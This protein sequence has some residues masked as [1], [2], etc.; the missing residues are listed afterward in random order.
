MSKQFIH[1]SMAVF[2][3]AGSLFAESKS[4]SM[5]LKK[6]TPSPN[7][8]EQ[9]FSIEKDQLPP[10]YGAPSRINVSNGRDWFVNASFIYWYVS[11]DAMDIAS[12]AKTDGV[13]EFLPPDS[14]TLVQDFDYAPGFKVGLGMNVGIDDWVVD[15]Q[16]TRIA[17]HTTV[18]KKPPKGG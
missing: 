7:T 6:T 1:L 9:G 11:Q 5:L 13:I 10:A 8:Y 16:Y 18:S 15:L 3:T 17:N 12:S 2:L 4:Q 14:A